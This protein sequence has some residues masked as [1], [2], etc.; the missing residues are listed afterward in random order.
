MTTHTEAATPAV[1]QSLP[2]YASRWK[3]LIFISISLMVI[4]IDNTILNVAL[5]SISRALDASASE[6]QWIV[7]SYVLVFASLLLTMGALG[8]KFGRKRSLQ[9][10]MILFGL[11]S[12]GAALS[13]STAFLIGARAF[14]GI[15]GA[16]IMPA[17]LSII[18]VT[19]PI[20][21]RA[22]AFAIWATIFGLGAGIGP[23]TGGVVSKN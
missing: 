20:S 1:V 21:E 13:T 5:P 9:V 23:L 3:A 7:D 4:T 14:M 11:G 12:I 18:N 2:G 22:R 16:F 17:T 6:L 19:F 10:G 8:D 15:G